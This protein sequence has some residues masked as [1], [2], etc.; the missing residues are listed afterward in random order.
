MHKFQN[1]HNVRVFFVIAMLIA[2]MG[3]IGCRKQHMQGVRPAEMNEIVKSDETAIVFFR[4][5]KSLGR[6]VQA[7]IIEANE[8]GN[9]SYIAVINS[10][11]KYLHRTTPG[12]HMYFIGS[13]GDN[14]NKMLEANMEAGKT[15]YVD[16]SPQFG[17]IA[18]VPVLNIADESFK[19]A[20]ASCRWV[21]NRPSAQ[22]WFL[23]NL[24]SL[25]KKYTSALLMGSPIAINPEYGSDTPV[26]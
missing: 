6:K 25:Q 19:K 26:Q 21:K 22:A 13:I 24:P 3:L 18:F 16:I 5:A 20:L 10:R 11:Y 8:D 9:L 2:A 1:W 4:S 23:D 14:S 17:G 12:K 7:P 15:Y